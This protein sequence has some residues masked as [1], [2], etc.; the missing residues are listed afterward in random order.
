MDV[1]GQLESSREGC[2]GRA[3][4]GEMLP[5]ILHIILAA[6]IQYRIQNS[7]GNNFSL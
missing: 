4:L 7:F 2:G 1:L 6:S 3:S 5:S